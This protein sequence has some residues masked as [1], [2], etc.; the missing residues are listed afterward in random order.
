[1]NKL[2]MGYILF[3]VGALGFLSFANAEE[4]TVDVP[5]DFHG[6]SCHFD[7]ISIEYQC[8]WQGT[9]DIMTEEEVEQFKQDV[10]ERLEIR[11]D[12]AIEQ[13][14][15]EALEQANIEHAILT[16]NEK[17]IQQLEKKI[18]NGRADTA[19]II[20]LKMIK[21]LDQCYQG[22]GRSE[23]IQAV[24]S[25][26]ISLVENYA[27][28]DLSANYKLKK[29]STAIQ[30]CK[31]QHIM[32]TQTL[33]A[34]YDHFVNDKDDIWYDHR[35]MIGDVQAVPYDKLT[36]TNRDIDWS[37]ICDNNQFSIEH[38]L[39]FDCYVTGYPTNEQINAEN[40]LSGNYNE[41]GVIEIKSKVFDRYNAFMKQYGNIFATEQDKQ[42]EA[43]KAEIIVEEKL[44]SNPWHNKD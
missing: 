2:L 44:S 6:V 38:K 7:E 9:Q 11:D 14:N 25:F 30:E 35:A 28:V 21:E 22:L 5:F 34:Q 32:E 41:S 8:V 31:A 18:M 39:Q 37:A 16:P 17:L 10:I 12:L 36:E 3:T 4:Y 26:E 13:L 1:M 43:E 33:S 20:L 24:R 27:N 23:P 42:R 40:K 19:D 29:L 15:E